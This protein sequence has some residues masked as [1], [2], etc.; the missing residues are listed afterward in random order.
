[1]INYTL[2][3]VGQAVEEL[4][5]FNWTYYEHYLEIRPENSPDTSP[6]MDINLT[7]AHADKPSKCPNY[8]NKWLYRC[9][10]YKQSTCSCG[11]E[12]HFEIAAP[13]S[14]Q[15]LTSSCCE[16]LYHRYTFQ[17]CNGDYSNRVA[18]FTKVN[19]TV[20]EYVACKEEGLSYYIYV[21]RKISFSP[22]WT[23]GPSLDPE[24]RLQHTPIS[25]ALCPNQIVSWFSICDPTLHNLS[26][27]RCGG[28]KWIKTSPP[29]CA[30]T[31]FR[32]DH[33]GTSFVYNMGDCCKKME[34]K[35]T[36]KDGIGMKF[37]EAVG[38][39]SVTSEVVH[40]HD[41]YT[42]RKALKL[43]DRM[44]YEK[45]SNNCNDKN[46]TSSSQSKKSFP[47]RK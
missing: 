40:Q 2:S 10:C 33:T 30:K 8:Y 26:T 31:H 14:R 28:A 27:S 4:G 11:R 15:S 21:D 24:E 47:S 17:T 12:E 19:S 6:P 34:I 20:Y 41:K 32:S 22:R 38:S 18:K 3:L 46:S 45:D 25:D 29:Q 23:M 16:E 37:P 36:A 35:V 7:R 1:M 13:T 43:N 39:Y 42:L 44:I 5:K 9:P